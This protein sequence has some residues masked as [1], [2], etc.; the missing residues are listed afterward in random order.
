M[1]EIYEILKKSIPSS[2]FKNIHVIEYKDNY[3]KNLDDF[4]LMINRINILTLQSCGFNLINKYYNTKF[5]EIIEFVGYDYDTTCWHDLIKDE[6]N[7]NLYARTYIPKEDPYI[8]MNKIKKDV[9]NILQKNKNSITKI[10]NL[11]NNETYLLCLRKREIHSI[12]FLDLDVYH[13]SEIQ[14]VR[15]DEPSCFYL[16]LMP[17]IDNLFDK[18]IK[19]KYS[20]IRKKDIWNIKSISNKFKERF[21]DDLYS[22]IPQKQMDFTL[23]YLDSKNRID[24][25]KLILDKYKIPYI[26]SSYSTNISGLS[27]KKSYLH[28]FLSQNC[29]NSKKVFNVLTKL[30]VKTEITLIVKKISPHSTQKFYYFISDFLDSTKIDDT[31][32]PGCKSEALG[33]SYINLECYLKR[34]ELYDFFVTID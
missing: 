32:K 17:N 13:H 28:I 27:E 4:F 20:K 24:N 29:N 15:F 10:S 7:E 31:K 23:S 2:E 9:I 8:I 1:K 12:P 5:Y 11:K 16:M 19:N 18:I 25:C 3:Y 14:H 22:Y 21:G 33:K 30:L 34:Y 26:T 6:K